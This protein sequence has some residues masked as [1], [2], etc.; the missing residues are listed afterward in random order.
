[1]V[2]EERRYK[3]RK[4]LEDGNKT[5]E[6]GRIRKNKKKWKKNGEEEGRIQKIIKMLVHVLILNGTL[7]GWKLTK[8]LP[9][10]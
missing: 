8:L 1:M 6:E 7:K 5:N 10:K 4:I 2:K 3:K 9:E